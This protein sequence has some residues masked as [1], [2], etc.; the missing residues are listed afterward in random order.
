MAFT[1]AQRG[2]IEVSFTSGGGSYILSGAVAGGFRFRDKVTNG[3]TG[4]LIK[5]SGYGT[6]VEFSKATFTAPNILTVTEV[7]SSSNDNLKVSWP[8]SG[9]RI[10][11]L[12]SPVDFGKRFLSEHYNNKRVPNDSN[13]HW[14]PLFTQGISG[15]DVLILELSIIQPTLQGGV[16]NFSIWAGDPAH[17]GVV[18]W[19]HYTNGGNSFVSDFNY[20]L[21]VSINIPYVFNTYGHTNKLYIMFI[22]Q[23]DTDIEV[24]F[25][26]S[27]QTSPANSAV[28]SGYTTPPVYS[29]PLFSDVYVGPDL[30]HYPDPGWTG[31]AEPRYAM[32]AL[33]D[34]GTMH[35]AGGSYYLPFGIA[36]DTDTSLA[37]H[38]NFG[39]NSG[40]AAGA[41]RFSS[42]ISIIGNGTYGDKPTI[43]N[44][45]GGVGAGSEFR[46]TFGKGFILVHA[47]LYIEGIRFVKC[48]GADGNGDGEAG[49]YCEQFKIAGGTITVNKCAGY[50]NENTVFATETESGK[51]EIT[52]VLD[53]CDFGGDGTGAYSYSNSNGQSRDGFSH[54]IYVSCAHVE[55]DDCNFYGCEYGNCVKSRSNDLV[56][57]N[58]YIRHRF[59]RAIDSPSGGVVVVT[60]TTFDETSPCVVNFLGYFNEGALAVPNT[61]A[62]VNLVNCILNISRFNCTM[63]MADTG[64][65]FVFTSPTLTYYKDPA[66]PAPTIIPTYDNV[67]TNTAAV[68]G[69]SPLTSSGTLPSTPASWPSLASYP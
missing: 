22:N 44:G 61:L 16:Y 6:Q 56:I 33:A 69:L 58:G 62:D 50:T 52:L 59:G 67:T 8:N 60:G 34:G 46:L 19:D 47:P 51:G 14:W 20:S 27:A 39:P 32:S 68:T 18:V 11:E 30:I 37:G 63:W 24:S 9:Q 17:G 5:V 43:F 2:V 1:E 41:A 15:E 12:I 65:K 7:I 38:G 29:G 28:L 26:I 36:N 40:Q 42:G 31:F 64:H 66:A 21:P 3:S 10:I 55:I 4:L 45:R 25:Q 35:V 48:G 54:D 57:N 53:H 23:G 13:Y 49:I